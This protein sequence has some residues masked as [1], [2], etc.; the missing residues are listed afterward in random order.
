MAWFLGSLPARSVHPG[1]GVPMAAQSGRLTFTRA[2]YGGNVRETVS[3]P[4]APAVATIKAGV[5]E[6]TR[7]AGR[8]GEIIPL[9]PHSIEPRVRVIAR[10]RDRAEGLSLED[11]K[12]IVAGGR[13]L[14]GAEGFRVLEELA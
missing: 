13:G 5:G 3:F 4:A 7:D 12:V 9:A 11:A 14:E 8:R 6:A 2:C 10:E 1:P